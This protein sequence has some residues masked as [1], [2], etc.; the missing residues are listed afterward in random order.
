MVTFTPP[1][2]YDRIV[3]IEMFEHMKNYG[4]LM[5]RISNWLKPGGKLFVHI[6]VHK[7]M[8][9]HFEVRMCKQWKQERHV[10]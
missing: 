4:V 1:G 10:C 3:S 9:Y 7:T 5:E 6:F 8:P 2:E